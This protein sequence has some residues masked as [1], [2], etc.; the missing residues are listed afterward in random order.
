M[1][2]YVCMWCV[3]GGRFDK[4]GTLTLVY[5]NIKRDFNV[6][7]KKALTPPLKSYDIYTHMISY[8]YLNF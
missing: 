7:N 6:T 1:N 5:L 3:V 4:L 2:V 8:E